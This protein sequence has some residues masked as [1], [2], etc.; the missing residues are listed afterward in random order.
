MTSFEYW[1]AMAP[2]GQFMCQVCFCSRSVAEA[3]RDENGDKWDE[4]EACKLHE[5]MTVVQLRHK[6]EIAELVD[7]VKNLDMD[8][9]QLKIQVEFFRTAAENWQDGLDRQLV[10][11]RDLTLELNHNKGMV[12]A[13]RRDSELNAADIA[14]LQTENAELRKRLKP[15]PAPVYVAPADD[16]DPE[17][18]EAWPGCFSGGYDPRCCR[19]PKSCS[20]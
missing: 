16:R 20:C 18:V 17:C 19:F 9:A 8:N 4:C 7:E 5:G 12:A 2:E 11:V 10:A 1:A 6:E 3:W 13:L 14:Q 15:K